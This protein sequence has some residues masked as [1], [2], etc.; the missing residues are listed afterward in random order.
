MIK[1]IRESEKYDDMKQIIETIEFKRIFERWQ[2]PEALVRSLL[3]YS[4]YS[5]I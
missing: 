5:E 4:Y 1:L 3:F 2:S